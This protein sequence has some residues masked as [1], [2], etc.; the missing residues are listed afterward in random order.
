MSSVWSSIRWY[1]RLLTILIQ[2]FY[3]RYILLTF[4]YTLSDDDQTSDTWRVDHEKDGGLWFVGKE[5]ASD[6]TE[7]KKEEL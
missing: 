2:I 1:N 5:D 4:K 3:L 7:N 6:A